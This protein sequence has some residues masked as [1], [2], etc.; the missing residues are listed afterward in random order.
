MKQNA[1]GESYCQTPKNESLIGTMRYCVPGDPIPW[2]RP[3][4]RGSRYFDRQ[5]HLKMTTGVILSNQ[6][7]QNPLFSG[8]LKADLVFYF[9][10]PLSRRSIRPGDYYWQK[11]DNDNLCGFYFDAAKG[12]ILVDDA[13]ICNQTVLKFYDI[14]PRTELI[15]TRL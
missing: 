5:K 2:Q 13:M 3:G 11:P 6:H 12:I 7:G 9:K 10:I 1:L 4:R 15:I 8:P 14:E